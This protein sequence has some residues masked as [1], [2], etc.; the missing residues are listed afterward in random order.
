MNEDISLKVNKLW[1]NAKAVLKIA[2]YSIAGITVLGT[3]YLSATFPGKTIE[4]PKNTNLSKIAGC[5]GTTWRA[6]KK[7]N[8]L[9]NPD[10]IRAGDTL[11]IYH[12][13]PRGLIEYFVDFIDQYYDKK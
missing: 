10:Y 13:G 8:N 7:R 4:I 6:L 1:E 9:E 11:I 5:N 12:K 2:A 3:A